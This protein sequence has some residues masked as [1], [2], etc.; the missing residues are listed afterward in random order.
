MTEITS[1]IFFGSFL[2][3]ACY[4]FAGLIKAKLKKDI[5]NPLIISIVLIIGILLIFDIEYSTYMESAKYI[6][7]FLTPTTICLA[8]PLYRQLELLKKNL[9]A[10]IIGIFTGVVV[11]A[12]S[13]YLLAITLSLNH[14]QYITLL[15]KS[16]TSAIGLP[17]SEE[18]GGIGEITVAIIALTGI[19][20]NFFA[21]STLRLFKIKS[22]IAKGVGIGTSSHALGTV[23]AMEMGEIEGAM[24]SLSIAI[25]GIITVFVIQ[26]FAYLI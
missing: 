18:F 14:Q 19:A 1:S 21:K 7:Y 4:T 12:V 5:F 13:I 22:P 15:P 24:S 20:G 16:I 26:F 6:N 10:I 11:S 17:L 25:T 3:L 9:L 8:L 23:K 2:T